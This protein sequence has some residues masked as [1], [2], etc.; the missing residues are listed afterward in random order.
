M[1]IVNDVITQPMVETLKS[2][3]NKRLISYDGNFIFK[4]LDE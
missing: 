3:L 1:S 4:K 2:M